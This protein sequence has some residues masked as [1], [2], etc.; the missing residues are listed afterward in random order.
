VSVRKDPPGLRRQ[1]FRTDTQIAIKGDQAPA[2]PA[3]Y[4]GAHS[5]QIKQWKSQLLDHGS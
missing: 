2:D 3:Q 1:T 5:N 4:F